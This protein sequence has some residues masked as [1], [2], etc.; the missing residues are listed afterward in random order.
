MQKYS[1]KELLFET[2]HRAII[3]GE[4]YNENQGDIIIMMDREL[5]SMAFR[6]KNILF[7]NAKKGQSEPHE[8][9]KLVTH[10]DLWQRCKEI[11]GMAP[12]LTSANDGLLGR[13]WIVDGVA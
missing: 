4:Y 12:Y 6:K 8:N 5:V 3:N 7:L 2:P 1:S 13:G 11:F 9:F 10:S